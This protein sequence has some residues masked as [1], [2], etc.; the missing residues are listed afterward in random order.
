MGVVNMVIKKNVIIAENIILNYHEF[1]REIIRPWGNIYP[2]RALNNINFVINEGEIVGIIGKNG[3]GKS[4]LLKCLAGLLRPTSGQIKTYG[5]I[6]LLAGA[7]PGLI[8]KLTGRQNVKELATAYGLPIEDLPDFI[9]SIEEFADLGEAFDRSFG[10]YSTGMR[11]K[12][13][14]G[15]ITALNPDVLLIDETLGVGDRVFRAK[16][17]KRLRSFIDRSAT[18]LISTHS[19][20]LAKELCTRG[21]VLE[22]GVVGFDGP[23]NDAVDY[24]ISKN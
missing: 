7:N 19:L 2:F 9:K 6:F 16:A 20:G 17:E 8:L 12:L 1:K 24:Y 3:A 23:I 15:F 14:F 4:T 13:G 21:I 18:V 22:K 10:G 11:G 5:R